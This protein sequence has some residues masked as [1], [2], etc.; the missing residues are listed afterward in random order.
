MQCSLLNRTGW[1]EYRS[2]SGEQCSSTWSKP[3]GKESAELGKLDFIVVKVSEWECIKSGIV[4]RFCSMRAG[5]IASAIAAE[6][7]TWEISWWKWD[8]VNQMELQ[9]F[10][11][12]CSYSRVCVKT[13]RMHLLSSQCCS[14]N[15][16]I[17]ISN[18]I[19]KTTT[20]YH[21]SMVGIKCTPHITFL[22]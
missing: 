3:N 14:L 22:N 9:L 10:Q 2:E 16:V 19:V 11:M 7:E 18:L 6:L 5:R 1:T 20:N 21:P 17:S 4:T 12:P 15:G 13:P 8:R